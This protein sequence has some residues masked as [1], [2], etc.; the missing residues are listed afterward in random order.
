MRI[1]EDGKARG[2]AAAG[3]ETGEVVLDDVDAADTVLAGQGVRCKGTGGSVA[4]CWDLEVSLTGRPF[5][6]SMAI[7]SGSFGCG[8]DR[9]R[10]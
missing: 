1:A 5:S 8:E 10:S 7:S 6:E 4:T 9:V 3:F 2:L